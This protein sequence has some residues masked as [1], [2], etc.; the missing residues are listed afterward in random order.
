M[1][2]APKWTDEHT[3]L[4][5][6]LWAEGLTGTQIANQL[7]RTKNSVIGK[8]HRLRLTVRASPIV[9]RSKEKKPKPATAEVRELV[10]KIIPLFDNDPEPVDESAAFTQNPKSIAGR[11]DA[12]QYP[13]GDP[14]KP[15]FK[16]CGKHTDTGKPYCAHHMK[17]AYLPSKPK[18]GAIAWVVK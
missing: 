4:I 10:A 12:C 18:K 16:Y 17:L 7:G 14:G 11:L 6:K 15:N 9:R 2:A 5:R 3:A 1:H 8:A 13:S